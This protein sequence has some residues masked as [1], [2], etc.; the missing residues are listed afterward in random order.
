MRV[1]LAGPTGF[2]GREVLE[3]CLQNATITS[4]IAL[5]RSEL[6]ISN[7]KLQV[8]IVDNF[9]LYPE[10]LLQ[11]VDGAEAA[12]WSLGKARMPDNDQARQVIIDYTLAAA[13]AFTPTSTTDKKFRFVYLSG[14]ASERDQT[15]PL[16]FMQDY[17]RIRG[18]VENDLIA[19][20]HQASDTFESY[21]FRPGFVLAKEANLRDTIRGLGPS[22]KVDA[23]ASAM[24]NVALVGTKDHIVENPAI[25]QL[26]T[27]PGIARAV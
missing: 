23:L 24:I 10:S 8:R 20:A 18:Q 13:Q 12:I 14:A 26:A 11:D 16:W 25:K 3:Q 7:P 15:K 1:I 17:R 2:I 9:L 4:I 21:I 6:P 22:V 27:S 5:S 19:H